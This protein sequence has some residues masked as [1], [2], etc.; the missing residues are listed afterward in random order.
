MAA[1]AE[2]S[3][4]LGGG[5]GFALTSPQREYYSV[6]GQVDAQFSWEL[7]SL[8]DVQAGA[9][10][11]LLPGSSGLPATL[12]SPG[13]MGFIG[14]GLRLKRPVREAPVI[15]WLEGLAGF[16]GTGPLGRFGLQGAAGLGF[17][18]KE[19]GGV[20]LGPVARVS[21]ILSAPEAGFTSFDAVFLSVGLQLE[22][23]I[24]GSDPAPAPAPS[25]PPP[26]PPVNADQDGDGL[27]DAVDRCPSQAGPLATHGCPDDD[28]DRDGVLASVD[29]CPREAGPAS[30]NGCPDDDPDRD[31]VIGMKDR[32]PDQS[33]PASAGGCPDRDGDTVPDA[34]DDC[35]E[36]VGAP[37]NGGCPAYKSVKVTETKLELSQ[38]IFFAFGK[39]QILNKSFELLDEVVAALHDHQRLCV[40]IEGHTD[41][42]GNAQQNLKLSADRA[43]AVR[44]YLV[45]H[46]IQA[47]RLVSKGFGDTEPLDSNGTTEGREKNRRVEFVIVKC[48]GVTP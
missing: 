16:V 44:E 46:G 34:V 23:L 27:T 36:K 42:K 1:H 11:L 25:L 45:Q 24:G 13:A 3:L 29:K 39:A 4:R 6:G 21:Y 38:K 41:S 43:N 32:C 22:I 20:L 19:S 47:W 35:P 37:E 26:P 31:G 40:R 15:P 9:T 17:R 30:N 2:G 12:K 5:A 28:V 18:L 10:Y 33:G 14:A 8:L 7:A 48:E